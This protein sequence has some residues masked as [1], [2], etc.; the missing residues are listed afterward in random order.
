MKPNFYINTPLDANKK[1]LLSSVPA[2]GPGG[3]LLS[4]FEFPVHSS[5]FTVQGLKDSVPLALEK[6]YKNGHFL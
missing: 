2:L 1:L 6:A 5:R 3:L 4:N